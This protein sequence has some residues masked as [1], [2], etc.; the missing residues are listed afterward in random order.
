MIFKSARLGPEE[1][2]VIGAISRMYRTVRYA[3]STAPRWE[4]I[5]CRNTTARAIRGSSRIGGYL[6]TADDALAATD[7]ERLLDAEH[8]TTRIV[9]GN[10]SAMTYIARLAK[11]P[12]LVFSEGFLRS[13]HFIMLQ[14]DLS[15]N[16][17]NWR[18]GQYG[19][20][21]QRRA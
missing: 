2:K 3:L 17:G 19:C 10:R 18:T 11:D 6:L 13:I 14:H 7:D 15:K 4:Q 16:P 1:S 9:A 5:L 20:V 21:T 8:E 12:S